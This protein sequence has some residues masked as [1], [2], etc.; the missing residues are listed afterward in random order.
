MPVRG[1]SNKYLG[2]PKCAN[3]RRVKAEEFPTNRL[4][5][6]SAGGEFITSFIYLSLPRNGNLIS[7]QLTLIH[8]VVN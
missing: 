1:R 6:Y 4:T 2:R 7:K 8:A 3:S 5:K